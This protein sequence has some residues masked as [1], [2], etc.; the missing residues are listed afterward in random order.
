MAVQ[1]Q[2]LKQE[3]EEE[4]EEE[5]ITRMNEYSLNQA[6]PE[7]GVTGWGSYY[8][9]ILHNKWFMKEEEEEKKEIERIGIAAVEASVLVY[10][11]CIKGRGQ[12]VG[13]R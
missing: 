6:N 5:K 1:R 3:E 2:S 11:L 10:L 7:E 9:I 13:T 4:E 12:G 8:L